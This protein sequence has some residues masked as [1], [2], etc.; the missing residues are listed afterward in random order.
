MHLQRTPNKQLK[1][2]KSYLKKT[3]INPF[4]KQMYFHSMSRKYFSKSFLYRVQIRANKKRT[5]EKG[6][7]YFLSGL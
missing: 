7:F 1:M 4:Y 6:G 2:N 3:L 5:R